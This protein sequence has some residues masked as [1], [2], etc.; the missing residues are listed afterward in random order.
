VKDFHD[1]AERQT[2]IL[3]AFEEANWA[4]RVDSPFNDEAALSQAL[5]ALNRISPLLRIRRRT[6]QEKRNHDAERRGSGVR[7]ERIVEV[8]W[9]LTDKYVPPHRT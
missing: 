8:N 3:D 9:Y 2:G 6:V 1:E 7:A 4:Y 5:K